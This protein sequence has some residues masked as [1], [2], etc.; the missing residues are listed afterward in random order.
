MPIGYTTLITDNIFIGNSAG[1]SVPG[2]GTGTPIT[3]LRNI[4]FGSAVRLLSES[5]SDQFVLGS[6]ANINNRWF[7]SD[8]NGTVRQWRLGGNTTDLSATVPGLILDI[9][10]TGGGVR[11]PQLTSTEMGALGAS[12][13]GTEI[14]NTTDNAKMVFDGTNWTGFRYNAGTSKYQ[15]GIAAATIT[16][17]VW[18][19]L[20]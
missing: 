7:I 9:T 8:L 14:Y 13:T 16:T 1:N 15:G 10:G 12:P 2:S 4:A 11:M 17:I 20:N 18:T 5:G 3:G 19:D 6:G